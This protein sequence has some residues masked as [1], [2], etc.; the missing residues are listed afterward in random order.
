MSVPRLI[1]LAVL[2][3]SSRGGFAAEEIVLSDADFLEYLAHME[4]EDDDWTLLAK[5]RESAR[6]PRD[7]ASQS[8]EAVKDA[9]EP[10]RPETT[11]PALNR[12]MNRSEQRATDKR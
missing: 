9:V 1:G 12:D 3:L 2:L 8:D 11:R 7:A 10:A 6:P 4:G 5:P